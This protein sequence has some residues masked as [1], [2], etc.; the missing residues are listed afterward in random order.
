[1]VI[2]VQNDMLGSRDGKLVALSQHLKRVA[3]KKAR[4][5][6]NLHE[7]GTKS[8]SEAIDNLE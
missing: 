7:W 2:T 4:L 3:I 6:Q 5:E 8:S 1:M